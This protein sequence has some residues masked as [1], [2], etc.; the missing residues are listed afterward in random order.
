MNDDIPVKTIEHNNRVKG[1][2]PSSASYPELRGYPVG[3]PHNHR[4]DPRQCV[5]DPAWISMA[6]LN[7]LSMITFIT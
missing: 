7:H 6:F 2:R 5:F 3:D 1:T 4:R